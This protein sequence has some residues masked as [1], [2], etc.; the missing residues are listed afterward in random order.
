MGGK[1]LFFYHSLCLMHLFYEKG[2]KYFGFFSRIPVIEF[3]RSFTKDFDRTVFNKIKQQTHLAINAN[4][5]TIH[6]AHFIGTHLKGC[7][8]LIIYT[9]FGLS[10]TVAF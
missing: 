1:P 2:L 4:T 9:L 3:S 5:T 6:L 8:G 7:Y 10:I